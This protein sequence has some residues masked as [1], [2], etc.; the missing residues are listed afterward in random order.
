[1]ESDAEDIVGQ[2]TRADIDRA[3]DL[4][5]GVAIRT[6]LIPVFGSQD[7]TVL[8]KPESIQPHGSFKLRCGSYAVLSV[9]EAQAARGLYTASAGNF[10]QGVAAAAA[11]RGIKVRVYAPDSAART[12]LE[13]MRRLGAEVIEV[14]F[15]RWWAIL[16]GAV[17]DGETAHNI[18]PCRGREVIVGNATIAAEI[19]EDAP[20]VDAILVPFGGGG[21]VLGIAAAVRLLAPHVAVIACEAA[22]STPLTSAFA[23][24][25]P[26]A[27]ESGSSFIDGIGGETVL[28][29]SW[30]MLRRHVSGTAVIDDEAAA[31]TVAM[32]F[33]QHRL[34]V[35]GAGAVPVAIGLEKP[36]FAGRQVAAIVS[37]GNIDE[38]TVVDILARYP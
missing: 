21:L 5:R 20:D 18:H 2:I 35:E 6:P 29:S 25:Q 38:R 15:P 14:P 34:V 16:S 7:R 3:R 1:V 31:R 12:K 30:P 9:P 26:V 8:L 13:A 4:L 33:R 10:G 32:L 11:R 27:V 17:P 28:P 19:L 23:A 36:D 22:S 24:G 37:G